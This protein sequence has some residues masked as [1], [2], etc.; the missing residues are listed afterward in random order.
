VITCLVPELG[1]DVNDVIV[2]H[3]HP[4]TD[5]DLVE[6]L[7]VALEHVAVALVGPWPVAVTATPDAPTALEDGRDDWPGDQSVL[8]D[9][10]T[11]EPLSADRRRTF[12][13][14]ER[15]D[16]GIEGCYL[17]G[18]TEELPVGVAVRHRAAWDTNDYMGMPPV[19]GPYAVDVTFSFT[20]GSDPEL[21]GADQVVSVTL[22]LGVEGEEIDWVSPGEA[23]DA[24][25]SDERFVDLLAG[26]P[27]DRWVSQGMAFEDD[28]WVA[29]LDIGTS[30]AD[31][32]PD[33]R[34]V[35]VVDARSGAVIDVRLE[36]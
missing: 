4:P 1:V 13:A 24:L 19:P 30:A 10:L 18:A 25:L 34:L 2:D 22:P 23:I 15:V 33:R 3:L 29:T 17:V 32:D 36:R 5:E 8:K 21:R 7:R 26:A 14:E 11:P 9:V 27:R 6:R 28:R 31:Q 12:V 35:G 20:R 16:S